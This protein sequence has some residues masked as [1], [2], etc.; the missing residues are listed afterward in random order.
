MPQ[1]TNPYWPSV[2]VELV[3]DR[4]CPNV[5]RARAMIEMALRSVG[6]QTDWTEWDRA[7]VTTP[8]EFRNYGSPTVLVNGRDVGCDENSSAQS[9]ANSCRVYMD[10]CGCVCGAPSARLIATAIRGARAA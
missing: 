1:T 3:Y 6:A 5:D 7:D 2:T 9:D 8:I 4:D 10:E